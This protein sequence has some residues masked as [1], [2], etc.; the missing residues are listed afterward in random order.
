M[1]VNAGFLHLPLT[2]AATQQILKD[3]LNLYPVEVSVPD[4]IKAVSDYFMVKI[5]DLKSTRRDRSI[6]RPRQIAMYLAKELT[7]KSLPEIGSAFER[8]HTTIMH[9]I[10][11]ISQL[12]ET[13]TSVASCVQTI[14]RSFIC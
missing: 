7:S 5:A 13:D 10:K 2:L 8:D 12:V 3:T 11:V 9:A 1:I 6:A 14:K 4:I